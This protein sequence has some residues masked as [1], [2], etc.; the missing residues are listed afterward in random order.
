MQIAKAI[1]YLIG[2]WLGVDGCRRCFWSSGFCKI[3]QMILGQSF[4][5]YK[6]KQDKNMNVNALKY[7]MERFFF[8][9][10]SPRVK[11]GSHIQL[12]VLHYSSKGI[13]H[14]ESE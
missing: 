3:K 1:L 12:S 4:N 6:A 8:S 9:N 5:T 14:D 11:E 13:K 10:N 7:K 2:L